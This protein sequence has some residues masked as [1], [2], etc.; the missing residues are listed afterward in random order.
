MAWAS[1]SIPTLDWLLPTW[2]TSSL[3]TRVSLTTHHFNG[4]RSSSGISPGTSCYHWRKSH[5]RLRYF[6]SR[7]WHFCLPMQTLPGR[8]LGYLS[9]VRRSMSSRDNTGFWKKEPNILS[10]VAVKITNSIRKTLIRTYEGA[11]KTIIRLPPRDDVISF[12][13]QYL[14]SYLRLN[15]PTFR[16]VKRAGI[17]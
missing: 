8:K 15:P 12:R 5:P 9:S 11:R 7:A 6:L 13:F 3:A 10:V 2:V 17:S 16:E 1:S 4:K 14:P